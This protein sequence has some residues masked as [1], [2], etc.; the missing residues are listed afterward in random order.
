MS[1]NKSALLIL[2]M[3]NTFDFPE[4]KQLLPRAKKAAGKIL[5]LKERCHNKNIPVIYLNDN[6]GKWRSNWHELYERCVN[7]KALGREIAEQLKPDERD[8]FVLKPKHSGFYG[9]TLN[10]LLESLNVKELILTGIAGNICVL[11]TAHDAHMR[12]YKVVVPK[13]CI[14]SNTQKDDNYVLNQFETVFGF[15]TTP[16]DRLRL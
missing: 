13:D 16:S 12:E 10:V 4:A 14:A 7:E 5:R 11:F 15:K 1:K 8:Y 3:L 6:F 9:T 2:D